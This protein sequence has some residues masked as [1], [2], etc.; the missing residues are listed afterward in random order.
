L[1]L[2]PE[3][4]FPKITKADATG[5]R[6]ALKKLDADLAG[7]RVPT[8]ETWRA[9]L[10][11]QWEAVRRDVAE[12]G[13]QKLFTLKP[14]EVTELFRPLASALHRRCVQD[15]QLF[16]GTV[17]EELRARGPDGLTEH[18]VAEG[19]IT[20]LDDRHV[21]YAALNNETPI[22]CYESAKLVRAALT[23]IMTKLSRK[24]KLHPLCD[25]L[26]QPCATFMRTL[27]KLKLHRAEDFRGVNA[28]TS[29]R[30]FE[31]L[32]EFRRACG[33]PVQKLCAEYDITP[34]D[35]VRGLYS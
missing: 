29:K 22:G 20:I 4:L 7:R 18:Q 9:A 23:E 32:T 17:V 33:G 24:G 10:F 15:E 3:A 2:S 13:R 35:G 27:E 21:L 16:R 5:N 19:L 31:G 26:R 25:N 1:D 11:E 30:F 28:A 8:E 12:G 6:P 34:G 14:V